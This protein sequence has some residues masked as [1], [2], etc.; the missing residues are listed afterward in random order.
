MPWLARPQHDEGLQ[1]QIFRYRTAAGHE[2][3]SGI[4]RVDLA[5]GERSGNLHVAFCPPLA[6]L[7]QFHCEQAA[8]PPARLKLAQLETYGA[9]IE[10][11]LNEPLEAE[12]VL[13]VEFTA[14]EVSD[15]PTSA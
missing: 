1:Q 7:P 2:T 3:I 15:E 11:R 4:L 10:F 5:R 12:A 9:R 6:K 14:A 13:A 8:G